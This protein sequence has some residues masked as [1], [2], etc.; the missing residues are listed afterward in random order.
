[1]Q[2]LEI[3]SRF[4]KLLFPRFDILLEPSNLPIFVQK[5]FMQLESHAS[6]YSDERT[7]IVTASA[8]GEAF[9]DALQMDCSSR[10]N[11]PRALHCIRLFSGEPLT[12]ALPPRIVQELVYIE[13]D[14]QL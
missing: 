5:F 14:V 11:R 4:S 9:S 7:R 12:Q 3:A 13:A 10:S 8:S 1:M 6:N 2:S